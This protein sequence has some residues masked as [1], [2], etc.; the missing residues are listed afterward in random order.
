MTDDVPQG[1][2]S[3]SFDSASKERAVE[4]FASMTGRGLEDARSAVDGLA[5]TKQLIGFG[6]TETEAEWVRKRLV[7]SGLVAEISISE[8]PEPGQNARAAG[9]GVP[10]GLRAH[11]EDQ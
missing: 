11:L 3:G 4:G 8:D 7:Q 5:D 1:T 10:Q 6:L 2:Q 9:T